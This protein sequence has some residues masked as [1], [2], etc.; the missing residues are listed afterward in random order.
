MSVLNY[1]IFLLFSFLLYVQ[2]LLSSSKHT[3]KATSYRFLLPWLGN[4][5][6]LSHGMYELIINTLQVPVVYN[7]ILFLGERWQVHRKLLTPTF[8]FKIL[9]NSIGIIYKNAK[10][11]SEQLENENENEFNIH[12]Y[13]EKCSLDIICGKSIVC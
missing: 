2:V 11:L 8:H 4:G 7:I 3:K 5:L 9:E 1:S 13:I 12:K 6:I 10:I